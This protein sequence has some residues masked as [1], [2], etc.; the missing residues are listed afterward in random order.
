MTWPQFC[1]DLKK[2]GYEISFDD[3]GAGAVLAFDS[4]GKGFV[5]TTEGT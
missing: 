1:G 4:R 2:L 5:L 3:P